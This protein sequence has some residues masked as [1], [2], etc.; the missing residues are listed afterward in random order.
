[1][2]KKT[3]PLVDH[4]TE[5]HQGRPQF[6][7]LR[8]VKQAETAMERQI[9]ESVYIDSLAAECPQGFLNLKSE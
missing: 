3:H 7:L 4:F 1:M 2:G 8:L 5:Q 9:W 6:V